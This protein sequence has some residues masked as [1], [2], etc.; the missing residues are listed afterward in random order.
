MPKYNSID[1][2][3]AKVFFKI[4]ENKDYQLLKPKT[5]EKGLESVFLSIYDDWFIQSENP[6]AKEYLRMTNEMAFL[7]YKIN[8]IKQVL[9][10]IYYN[11]T[12]EKM[13]FDIIDALS[14]NCNIY[15]DKSKSFT[16][17]MLDVLRIQVGELEI[18]LEMLKTNRDELK[19]S[20]SE[21]EKVFSYYRQI[22]GFENMI[23]RNIDENCTLAKYIEYERTAV[24]IYENHINKT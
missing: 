10:F 11:Q 5:R 3:P 8:T 2:I 20:D 23:K 18:D 16:N 15:L 14:L 21:Q 19:P 1:T 13:R 22:M 17:E 24:K 7:I 6:N 12:T 4:L 9:H